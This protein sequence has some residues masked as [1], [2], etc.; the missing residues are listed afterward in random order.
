MT[1]EDAFVAWLWDVHLD[2]GVSLPLA[3]AAF[4]AGWQAAIQVLNNAFQDEVK[5]LFGDPGNGTRRPAA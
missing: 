2:D 4:T 5:A 3:E 1:R